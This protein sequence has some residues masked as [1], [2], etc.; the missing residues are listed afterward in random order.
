MLTELRIY[1]PPSGENN[2]TAIENLQTEIVKKFKINEVSGDVIVSLSDLP[3]LVP[4]AKV[5]ADFT[6]TAMKLHGPTYN[7]LITYKNIKRTFLLPH[8]DDVVS[9]FSMNHS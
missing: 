2:T 5:T 6:S 1:M 4:R 9:L 3:L 8:T 7:I